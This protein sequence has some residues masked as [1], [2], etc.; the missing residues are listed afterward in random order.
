MNSNTT[1]ADG[2]APVTVGS[3]PASVRT[4]WQIR[5]VA[6][7]TTLLVLV[8]SYG[9]IY[10]SF[11]FEDPDPGLGTWAFVTVFLAINVTAAVAL[12]GVLR[13]SPRARTV[14]VG[15]G[16]LG[17]LW[18]IAKLVFWQETEALVFGLVNLACIALLVAPSSRRHVGR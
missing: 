6:V 8:T 17:V 1:T 12:A 5:L 9:A 4:L 2:N 13:R 3:T 14:L 11:Y 7:L 16:A 15:Y 18:S 10:F